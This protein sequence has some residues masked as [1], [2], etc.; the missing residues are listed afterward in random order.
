[1]ERALPL[2]RVNWRVAVKILG[3]MTEYAVVSICA[4]LIWFSLA[5]CAPQE[6]V[7]AEAEP[8]ANGDGYSER[9]LSIG[10]VVSCYE[11]TVDE[12]QYIVVYTSKGVAICPKTK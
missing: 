1:M 8:A 9:S 11:I 4:I 3:Y 6:P 12:S 7:K 10:S 5:G 2:G